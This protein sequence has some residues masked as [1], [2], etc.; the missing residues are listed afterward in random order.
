MTVFEGD[1]K[2]GLAFDQ[3]AY[4]FWKKWIAEDRIL[5]GNK[6]DNFWEMGDTGPCGPCSEIFYDHGD[7][8]YGGLPGTKDQ[9]G[10]RFIEIWNMVFMQYEQLDANTRIELPKK[11]IDTG[12]GLERITAVMQDVHDNYDID[13]FQNLIKAI[14]TKFKIA[15]LSN[16][17]LRVVADHLRACAFLVAD[18]V[19]PSNEGRGY[20]LR[21]IMRRAI[22]HGHSKRSAGAAK[23]ARIPYRRTQGPHA[24]RH[25]GRCRH[26]PQPARSQ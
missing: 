18:G 19:I 4:D 9:D 10:D 13:L 2:E 3:E 26:R 14:A 16:K 24:R 8:I 6:K 22:R 12:M 1:A 17:S 11:S 5:R 23:A 7:K 25:L 20:V 15:D 21:R